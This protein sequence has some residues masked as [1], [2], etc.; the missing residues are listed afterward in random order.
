MK[1]SSPD[2]QTRGRLKI[3]FGS[4]AGVGKTYSMLAAAHEQRRQGVD[5]VVG[6]IE[7]HGR[8]QTDALLKD[9]PVLSM[10]ALVY[11]GI[12]L[13]ELDLE[14]ALERK[15]EVILVDEL[16]HTN[17]P[18]S[19]HP[20]RWNDV[21]ELLDAGINV[22]TTLNV[23]H[24]ESLSDV[25]AGTTGVWVKE[26]VPDT[27]FDM[28]DDIVLVDIDPDD[29]LRRLREGNVYVM[30]GANKRAAENFFKIGN[31]NSLRE[32]ALRRMA[33]RVDTERSGENTDGL[34]A[35]LDRI[36]VV[37]DADYDSLQL[38]R[39]CKRLATA[40]K[41]PWTALVVERDDGDTPS[42][43]A[44]HHTMTMMERMVDRLGGTFQ[45][46]HDVDNVEAVLTYAKRYHFTK[47]IV[48]KAPDWSLSSFW[49]GRAIDAIIRGSGT[50][51]VL[52]VT[53]G[54]NV[55][56]PVQNGTGNLR[57]LFGFKPVDY[58]IALSIAT[59]ITLVGSVLSVFLTH[60]DQAL[61]YLAGGVIV[62]ARFC[63]GSAL[64]Y[65]FSSGLFYTLLFTTHSI[66]QGDGDINGLV[67][68]AVLL[69]SGLIT[70]RQTAVLHRQATA[71]HERGERTKA[72]YDLTRRLT[73][74]RGRQPVA[75]VVADHLSGILAVD[76]AIW[77]ANA[78]GHPAPV[79]GDLPQETYYKDFGAL[80]WCFENARP[81]GRGTTTM[82]SA[83]GLYL[84]LTTSAETLG[85]IALFPKERERIPNHEEMAEAES[86]CSLLASA[87]QR[88]R[89]GEI[90][91]QAIVE[92]ENKKLKDSLLSSFTHDLRTPLNSI[93]GTVTDL[94]RSD[95]TMDDGA[96][97]GMAK[98]IAH[99]TEQLTQTVS[100][101]LDAGKIE[102]GAMES[103]RFPSSID[104]RIDNALSRLSLSLGARVVSKNI[105]KNLPD[106]LMDPS[107]I[108]QAL[109]NIFENAIRF[110][111][112]QG[113]INIRASLK[114]RFVL[115][116][117]EDDG[118]GIV[119][120]TEDKIFDKFYSTAARNGQTGTG[121][122]L[123]IAAGIIRLHGGAIWADNRPE[124]GARISLTL[125]LA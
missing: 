68:F 122:G 98:T 57:P 49:K 22:F 26:T 94:M 17:A 51:D 82:P 107:L 9:L 35:V 33:E 31:L 113:N 84:P 76:C 103:Q 37:I 117:T 101:L 96:M 112:A 6:V 62:A 108:E 56:E 1:D 32:I 52:V 24:I 93:A 12:T 47:I 44:R 109:F 48:G 67:T 70:A 11:R 104:E 123:T 25:V 78:E 15:P 71:A 19:R 66:P 7:T 46:L 3:F 10:G 73:G 110:S 13:Y 60:T 30:P 28:A 100:R 79:L 61:L 4:S 59:A 55:P 53:V 114:G 88:V 18:G 99:Q 63:L 5:V 72:L 34:T 121:L 41:A 38:V 118:P 83:A 102:H 89:A 77:M 29:L 64:L 90:A 74:T 42:A 91:A 116:E 111:P 45:T 20:K 50:I 87:L 85:V 16:A 14:K 81:S 95:N 115:V 105:D 106:T 40:L 2:R 124:G 125:P 39:A 54:K 43:R 92:A 8:P 21:I 23:Q 58:L 80:Q 65:V 97:R 75:Q 120:G 86:I 27:V 69:L 119:K 36:L